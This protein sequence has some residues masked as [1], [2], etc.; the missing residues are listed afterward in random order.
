VSDGVYQSHAAANIQSPDIFN[1][2]QMNSSSVQTVMCFEP[3]QRTHTNKV[4]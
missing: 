2:V 4:A 1:F 3:K